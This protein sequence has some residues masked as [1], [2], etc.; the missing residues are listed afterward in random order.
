MK[1][2][3]SMQEIEQFG[4]THKQTILL[5]ALFLLAAISNTLVWSDDTLS[6][7]LIAIAGVLGMCFREPIRKFLTKSAGFIANQE[8]TVRW[9]IAFMAM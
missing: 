5:S 3:F 1:D 4:K 7:W 9:I 2:S 8:K 6:I